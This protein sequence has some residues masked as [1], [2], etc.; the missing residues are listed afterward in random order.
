[1][2][3]ERRSSNSLAGASRA[4][5]RWNTA[6]NLKNVWQAQDLQPRFFGCVA[7]KGVTRRNFLGV[8]E[9]SYGIFADEREVGGTLE[10]LRKKNAERDPWKP[11]VL[12]LRTAMT[13]AQDVRG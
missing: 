1:M 3:W 2:R 10:G 13:Q 12:R 7:S 8:V 5:T 4:R 6:L 11:L 9:E